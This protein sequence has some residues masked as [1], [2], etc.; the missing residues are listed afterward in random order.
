MEFTLQ[1]LKDQIMEYGEHIG[2]Q[3]TLNCDGKLV[4]IIQNYK[5]DNCAIEFHYKVTAGNESK[6]IKANITQL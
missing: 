6:L 1:A 3:P 2:T 5:I 4:Y